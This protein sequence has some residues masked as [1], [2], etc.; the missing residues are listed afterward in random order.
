M[1]VIVINESAG[2]AL[3]R[4]RRV[5]SKFLP[6]IGS[7]TWAGQIS[8]EGLADLKD[9]LLRAKASKATAIC[10]HRIVSRTRTHVEWTVGSKADFDEEGRF[11]FRQTAARAVPTVPR[12][13]SALERFIGAVLRLAGLFHDTGKAGLGYRNKLKVGHGA[14]TIRHDLLSFMV[15][16]ESLWTPGVTDE[17]WLT[18]LATTPAKACACVEG[19]QL[20][21]SSSKWLERVTNA[22]DADK[23]ILVCKDELESLGATA[24][25]LMTLLWLVLTHHRLPQGDDSA[26]QLDASRH[27]NKSSPEVL[28]RAKSV[29]PMDQCL[30]LAPGT[31]PWADEAWLAAVSTTAA[32]ALEA[33]AELREAATP[34]PPFFWFQL[35]AHHLRPALVLSDH[36]GSKQSQKT[37]LKSAPSAKTQIFANTFSKTYYAD[38]LA[39][40]ELKVSRLTRKVLNLA[41]AEMPQTTLGVG[42]R[43]SGLV[44][45][46]FEW[47]RDL[48][49][50]CIEARKSGPTFVAIVAETG[51]G[52]TLAAVRAASALRGGALRL[53]FA[54]GLRSLTWQSAEAMLRDAKIPESDIVVAVGQPETLGLAEQ[55]RSFQD[56]EA[57]AGAIRE[58]HAERFGSESSQG[59][60]VCAELSAGKGVQASWADALCTPEE[61]LEL[62]GPKTLALLSAPIVACTSD[63]LVAAVSLLKGGDAKLFLRLAT[64]DLILDEIDGYSAEDLQ[65]IAKLAYAAGSYG[66]NVILMSATMSPDVKAGLY[67]AWQQGVKLHCAL[68]AKPLDYCAIF[69]A[70]NEPSVLLTQAAPAEA[71]AAW[72]SYVTRVALKYEKAALTKQ[73]RQVRILPISGKTAADAYPQILEGAKSMHKENCVVDPQTG[74]RVSTGFVR[75]NRTRA[76]WKFANYLATQKFGESGPVVKF[77]SYHAK[78]PR[79]YLG[80]LDATLQKLATRKETAAGE[81]LE[82]PALR[83]VLNQYP[84]RDVIVIVSTTTLMETGR[85]FDFDWCILEPRSARGEVQAIGRV[86]RHRR[87]SSA[88][89]IN[90]LLLDQPLSALESRELPAWGMPGVEDALKGLRVTFQTPTVFASRDQ[91]STAAAPTAAFIRKRPVLR[92]APLA[93]PV[94]VTF[95]VDALPM[96]QWVKAFDAQVCLLPAR[97]YAS[98]RIGFLEQAVQEMHLGRRD[99]WNARDGLPPSVGFYFNSLAPWNAVHALRTR[100]RGAQESTLIFIPDAAGVQYWDSEAEV[101]RSL[102]RAAILAPVPTN[103]LLP[104]LAEQ[105]D[106]LLGTSPHIRGCSLRCGQGEGAAKELTWSPLLGFL[107]GPLEL[108]KSAGAS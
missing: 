73:L 83:K 29:A 77:I 16:A 67:R 17:S 100:F 42:S 64:A 2:K 13:V 99:A 55:A 50:R 3:I 12:Q 56:E 72:E 79:S 104:D 36:L 92:G 9:S 96:T 62:W 38:T 58:K 102:R 57:S 65:S 61:A 4:S 101:T 6:Q 74:A 98:N 97:A 78:V 11:S 85:D 93:A 105:A 23:G 27:L 51:S 34:L 20:L 8:A 24:P 45:P 103:A 53:T 22:L 108:T 95:A 87:S 86:R 7:G 15:H 47:Q 66:R 14:E 81:F 63:H 59:G 39:T 21:P 60:D 19:G 52:K 75:F 68:R 54:L 94:Y 91:G 35:A 26:E 49:A 84:G 40:H 30:K 25:G 31:P 107:E 48:E 41:Y 71:Q 89:G 80:V 88:P 18:T 28:T 10:C 43:A 5:L 44:P 70:S 76:A 1:N 32:H 37:V 69:A 33:L 106:R 82:T 90:V 46:A